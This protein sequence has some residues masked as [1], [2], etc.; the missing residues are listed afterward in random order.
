MNS[1]AQQLVVYSLPVMTAP[2][3]LAATEVDAAVDEL[4][5]IAVRKGLETAR[6]VSDFVLGLYYAGDIRAYRERLHAGHA[7]FQELAGHP[8]LQLSASFITQSIAVTEQARRMP[9][10]LAEALSFSHHRELL[11]LTDDQERNDLAREAV[12]EGLNRDQLKALVDRVVAAS[13]SAPGRRGRPRK[14]AFA[15]IGRCLEQAVACLDAELLTSEEFSRFT[16]S[17]SQQMLDESILRVRELET[18]LT[19]AR[20]MLSTMV[21]DDSSN[22]ASYRERGAALQ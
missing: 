1:S 2:R 14:P 4:N 9:N 3:P 22:E 5:R 10:E 13:E 18:R 6:A 15:Q 20:D 8:R 16:W 21:E 19:R 17:R 12:R 11:V 7:A